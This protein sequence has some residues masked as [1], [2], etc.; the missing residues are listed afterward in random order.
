MV[1]D[2]HRRGAG[3]DVVVGQVAAKSQTSDARKTADGAA[4]VDDILGILILAFVVIVIGGIGSIR[5][6]LLAALP[7]SAQWQKKYPVVKYGVI[8]VETQTSTTKTMDA[9]LHHAEKFLMRHW[10]L[11]FRSKGSRAGLF[12]DL[13]ARETCPLRRSPL[14]LEGEPGLPPQ[15]SHEK[16]APS[17]QS[18][19][20]SPHRPLGKQ[21]IIFKELKC[22]L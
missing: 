18:L 12:Y 15:I 6:A 16:T 10:Y 8:P 11:F 20:K 2:P 14:P 3:A 22:Y 1:A 19:Q 17:R 9:F 7:A 4:V 5:G 13:S 21:T